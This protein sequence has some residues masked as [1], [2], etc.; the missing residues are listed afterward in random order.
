MISQVVVRVTANG[1]TEQ[2]WFDQGPAHLGAWLF[3]WAQA[4][5]EVTERNHRS[6]HALP[7]ATFLRIG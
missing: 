6:K 1:I 7:H 3:A 4:R 5:P 2:P